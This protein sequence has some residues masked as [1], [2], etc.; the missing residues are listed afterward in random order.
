M[1]NIS[2]NKRVWLGV[3]FVSV[4]LFLML[5]NLGWL[6]MYIPSYIFSW[7]SLLMLIGL[8]FLLGRQKRDT[9]IVLMAVGGFFLLQDITY[10][11][12]YDIIGFWPLAFVVLGLVI[13]LRR[14]HDGAVQAANADSLDYIDELALFSGV[15]QKITSQYFRGGKIT[16]VFGGAVV[17][18][19]NARLAQGTNVI[20]IFTLFGGTEII[21]PHDCKVKVQVTA[22]FGAFDDSRNGE[23]V[24]GGTE[25][26]ELIIKGFV[27]FGGGELKSR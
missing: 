24:T 21:V 10:L 20:D 14:K 9:G 3:L 4:G 15:D 18:L 11:S 2:G 22:I 1:S 25:E 5:R 12:V 19:L 27:L 8:Y 16:P 13:I 23:L 26:G 7:K 17:N 6:P